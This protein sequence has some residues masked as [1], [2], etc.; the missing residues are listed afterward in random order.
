MSE[1]EDTSP[2]ERE[3]ELVA[4]ISSC[5]SHRFSGASFDYEEAGKLVQ[6]YRAALLSDPAVV[7]E[8]A[9]SILHKAGVYM[10]EELEDGT[11][12]V[13]AG[14]RRAVREHIAEAVAHLQRAREGSHGGGG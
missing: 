10:L 5:I 9:Q 3:R 8:A 12:M 14:H 2:S 1:R 6:A 13:D 7:L 4:D 11:W